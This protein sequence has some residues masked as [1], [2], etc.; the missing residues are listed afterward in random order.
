MKR[1]TD[2][3][4][5]SVMGVGCDVMGDQLKGITWILIECGL[6]F[7]VYALIGF[8]FFFSSRRRHTRLQGDWSSDVCSSDLEALLH[9]RC[10]ELNGDWERFFAWGY[11]RWLD[12]MR[13]GQRVVIRADHPYALPT[14]VLVE[15]ADIPAHQERKPPIAA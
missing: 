3:R 15:A 8:F 1:K 7:I 11:Q 5:C 4:E 14:A 10:I 13:A 2:V 9:L 12:Q 6:Y